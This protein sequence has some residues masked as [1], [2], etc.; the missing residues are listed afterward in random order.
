MFGTK[1]AFNRALEIA[2]TEP[3]PEIRADL[4]STICEIIQHYASDSGAWEIIVTDRV[5]F[6]PFLTSRGSK[7]LTVRQSITMALHESA[8]GNTRI[9]EAF[10]AFSQDPDESLS[11]PAHELVERLSPAAGP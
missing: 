5:P 3:S 9:L 4:W 1:S 11:G 7:T 6:L 2:K 10:R 8:Q